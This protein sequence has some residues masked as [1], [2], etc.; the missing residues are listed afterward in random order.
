MYVDSVR[1]VTDKYERKDYAIADQQFRRALS[2]NI[3][4]LQYKKERPH[5]R[6][7]KRVDL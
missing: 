6:N 7:K 1:T 3:T 4:L 2:E 5:C